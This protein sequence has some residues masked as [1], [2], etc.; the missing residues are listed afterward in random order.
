MQ[1]EDV[2]ASHEELAQLYRKLQAEFHRRAVGIASAAHELRTPLA[3][4]N[5]YSDLLL[6]GKLGP[7]NDAQ[8]DVLLEMK[9]KIGRAHV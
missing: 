2:P 6:G 8:R 1:L 7:L 9:A 3:I 5:G 4:L